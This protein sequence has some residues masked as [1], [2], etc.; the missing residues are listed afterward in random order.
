MS[1]HIWDSCDG[2]RLETESI[3]IGLSIECRYP[4]NIHSSNG[5]ERDND[6]SVDGGSCVSHGESL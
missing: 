6:N 4:T 1:Q 5:N 3:A 2:D